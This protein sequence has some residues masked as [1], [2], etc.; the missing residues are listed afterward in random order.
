MRL[1]NKLQKGTSVTAE[2]LTVSVLY[3]NAQRCVQEVSLTV[4]AGTT[5]W[6][7]VMQSAILENI[8]SKTRLLLTF[9]IWGKKIAPS[10]ILC[11]EDR[12]E[13]YRPLRVDPKVARR[14]RFRKQG[15]KTA[16]LFKTLR[17]GA[18]AGY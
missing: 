15:A 8:D 6:V 10:Q 14:E 9:G 3:S 11:D 4:H 1:F 2:H 5:A 17:S 18:K 16:G 13:I 7:A 12:I